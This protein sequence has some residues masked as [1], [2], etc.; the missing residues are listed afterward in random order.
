MDNS[1]KYFEEGRKDDLWKRH[2]GWFSLS[3]SDFREIQTRLVLEQIKILGPSKIG[4]AFFGEHIPTS[5]EEFRQAT[6]LTTYS[7]YEEMLMDK[8]EE[9]LPVKPFV[10]ARTTGTSSGQPKW[11]PYSRS[12]YDHFSDPII[13]GM[14]L[15]SC[16]EPGDVK[17]D[18]NDKFLMATAPPPYSSAY[19]MRSMR[20]NFGVIF[21]PSL[22]EGEKMTYGERVATGF[23][24]A[25]REGLDYFMGISVVLARM[26]EQFEQ[27]SP[28]TRPSRDLL[29]PFILWRLVK[30]L[31]ISKINK[32]EILPKDIW[33]LKGVMCGGTDTEIYGDKIEYYW[34]KKPLEGYANSESGT[35][36]IQAWNL[37][38]MIFYPDNAFLEFI[39]IAEAN[40]NK[41]DPGYIPKTVL[42]DELDLGLYELVFS[43]FYGGVLVR[44]RIGDLFEVISNDDQEIG[45]ELP[46]VRFYSRADYIIDLSNFV[47]FTEKDIW[48]TIGATGIEYEDWAARKENI[49]GN[50]VLHIYIELKPSNE[51]T[52]EGLHGELDKQFS[53]RFSDYRD[54]KGILGY[55][56]LV[57]TKLP[58]GSFNAYMKEKTAAGADLAHLKPPHMKP[59]DEIM[60]NLTSFL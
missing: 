25:L 2:C 22:E 3:R 58:P 51:I 29:N 40:K 48:K 32:R 35:M 39:P 41:T 33:H 50:S 17:L 34:G 4:K 5:V 13:G 60:K 38:G 30:A 27:Q 9:D 55:N 12:M 8:N 11:I 15:S 31:I 49:A 7:D 26:G 20:D 21:L 14:L 43:N 59:S 10:W 19:I 23:K 47:R 18:R 44:Y 36:A 45:S 6:P 24:L 54:I 28:N 1:Q 46:Q 42:Y 53:A 37:K 52:E 56:P 57:V 16:S